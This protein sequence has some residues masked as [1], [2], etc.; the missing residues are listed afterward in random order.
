MLLDL[1]NLVCEDN[2]AL[3]ISATLAAVAGTFLG[4]KLLKKVTL[5]FIQ[6][7]VAVILILISIAL[8]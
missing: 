3:V 1:D 8:E 4:N 5:K 2:M 6:R 7:L